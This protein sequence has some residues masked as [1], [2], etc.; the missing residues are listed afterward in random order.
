MLSY[1]RRKRKTAL[2]SVAATRLLIFLLRTALFRNRKPYID[3]YIENGR[4]NVHSLFSV[5]EHLISYLTS[6]GAIHGSGVLGYSDMSERESIKKAKQLAGRDFDVE[7]AFSTLIYH[8]SD[9]AFSVHNPRLFVGPGPNA[10]ADSDLPRLSQQ[11]Y[12]A[13]LIDLCQLGYVKYIG[14]RYV[15]TS[16]AELAFRKAFIDY[17]MIIR[18]HN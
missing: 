12:D 3:V 2:D 16:K 10:L 11:E 14:D 1:L 17:D 7:E 8:F 13:L 15:P 18:D 5:G 4:K 6:I 9:D